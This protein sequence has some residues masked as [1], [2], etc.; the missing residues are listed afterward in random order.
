MN[1]T[2]STPFGKVVVTGSFYSHSLNCQANE[3]KLHLNG[4]QKLGWAIIREVPEDLSITP[5][6]V[7]L[8]AQEAS[9]S[10]KSLHSV[11]GAGCLAV[12]S[13]LKSTTLMDN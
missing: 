3:L 12:A 6:L 8:F 7:E 2:Y 9:N 10:L 13:Q 5:E 11:G 1:N 4:H